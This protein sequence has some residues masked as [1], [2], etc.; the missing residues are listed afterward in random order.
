MKCIQNLVDSSFDP[1]HAEQYR[2]SVQF[3]PDGFSFCLF[4]PETKRFVALS[5]YRIQFRQHSGTPRWE[6]LS[7]KFNATFRNLEIIQLP[8]GK[9]DLAFSSPKLTLVPEALLREGS[10]DRYFKFNHNLEP[11]EQ[12]ISQPLVNEAMS[13]MFALPF[14]VGRLGEVWF[15]GVK[16]GSS[17]SCLL[18]T[19]LKS[20]RLEQFRKVYLN[21]WGGFFDLAVLQDGKLLYFN[22]FRQQSAEDLL[23]YVIFVLEQL[24]LVPGEEKITLLGDITADSPEFK[25]LYQYIQSLEFAGKNIEAEFSPFLSDVPFHK[26]FTLFNLPFCE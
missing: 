9:T 11:T 14:P 2:L 21:V 1:E 3:R 6:K 23:Y 15:A 13:A 24:G 25:L 10:A 19:L 5:D 17:C 26:Y 22:T 16:P 8:F 20:G 18:R 4:H 7:D 12:I